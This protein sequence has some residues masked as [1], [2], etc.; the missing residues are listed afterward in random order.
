VKLTPYMAKEI[1][2]LAATGVPRRE[3]CERFGISPSHLSNVLVGR[4]HANAGGPKLI[5]SW[6]VAR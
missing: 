1:R 3:L 2:E 5:K 6:T 4:F